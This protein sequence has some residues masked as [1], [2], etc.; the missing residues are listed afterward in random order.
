MQKLV[1]GPTASL[2]SRGLA[3]CPPLLKNSRRQWRRGQRRPANQEKPMNRRILVIAIC[4]L[5]NNGCDDT[6]SIF[7]CRAMEKTALCWL[8][9]DMPEDN[10]NSWA[11]VV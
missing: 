5:E 8:V 6:R 1:Q 10:G 2:S 9:S 3:P 4:Y 11:A 7:A